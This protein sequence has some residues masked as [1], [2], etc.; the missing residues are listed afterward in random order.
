MTRMHL[1]L[2]ILAVVAIYIA[3]IGVGIYLRVPYSAGASNL[4]QLYKDIIPLVIAIPAAYLAFAFQRRSSYL[5][6]L[7]TLWSHMVEAISAAFIYIETADPTEQQYLATLQKLSATIEEVRGVFKNIPTSASADG[8]YPFEPVKQIYKQIKDLGFGDMAKGK[9][10]KKIGSIVSNM[11]RENR[12]RLLAEFDRDKP[13][14]HHA[15]YAQ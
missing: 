3:A 2:V 13:T 9:D 5:Q 1:R 10:R 11:W 14:H 7:R 15:E 8:W 6:A 4:Y 12:S